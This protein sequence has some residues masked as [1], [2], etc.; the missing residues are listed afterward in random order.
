MR[1]PERQRKRP[2]S[3]APNP[4]V[5]SPACSRR[6]RVPQP[7]QVA[8][9]TEPMHRVAVAPR[10][11]VRRAAK[12]VYR[13]VATNR[14]GTT[15]RTPLV[16]C[17]CWGRRCCCISGLVTTDPVQPS[18][19]RLATRRCLTDSGG[20]ADHEMV[21]SSP[22]PSVA[23]VEPACLTLAASL[24]SPETDVRHLEMVETFAVR[25]DL[26]TSSQGASP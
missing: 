3:R 5:D 25:L 17:R 18:P 15:G 16:P 2:L 26:R 1:D 7:G 6:R 24:W 9:V 10:H 13:E 14:G 12:V 8:P 11:V 19:I 21:Q 4:L 20:H 23:N 22:S